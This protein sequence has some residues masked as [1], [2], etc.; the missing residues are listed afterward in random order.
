MKNVYDEIVSILNTKG[1][2]LRMNTSAIRYSSKNDPGPT[3]PGYTTRGVSETI[4]I[5][6]EYMKKAGA[7]NAQEF[8][9]WLKS[10]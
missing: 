3:V 9:N 8:L 10:Q 2:K 6:D 4:N 7:S 5:P 1:E